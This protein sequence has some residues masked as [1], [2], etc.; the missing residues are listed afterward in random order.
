[1]NAWFCFAALT[2]AAG[3]AVYLLYCKGLA[4][5]KSIAAIIFV[6]RP[7]RAAD[8]VTLDSCTGWVKHVG[9][10]PESRT[11]AFTFDAQL[12]NGN[13]EVVLL[14]RKKRQL[15]KLSQQSPTGK[16]AL[17]G[18]DRYYLRWDFKHATGKCELRW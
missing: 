7:G 2:A 6:F 12:S 3:A 8:R 17:D 11:Y 16:I 5:S 15:L 13:A 4:V 9:R 10:F 14:D 1:M 18:K